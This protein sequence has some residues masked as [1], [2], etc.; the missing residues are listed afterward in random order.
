MSDT[1]ML[2]LLNGPEE[3]TAFKLGKRSLSI[4]RDKGNLIQLISNGVSRRHV[5]IRW[6]PG[7]YRLSDLNSTNGTVVN[8]KKVESVVLAINDLLQIGD[9]ELRVVP[10]RADVQDATFSR[11]KVVHGRQ[12]HPTE[13]LDLVT[14][15]LP[16]EEEEEEE[17]EAASSAPDY[18][19]VVNVERRRRR[20]TSDF[21]FSMVQVTMDDNYL[22]VA[23]EMISD[24][25]APD[26]IL[27][28]GAKTPRKL[29]VL[30]SHHRPS[31]RP[32]ERRVGPVKKVLDAAITDRRPVLDNYIPVPPRE[33]P[34]VGTAAAVC[35]ANGMGAIYVDS[36][37]HQKKFFL[38]SD[39][40]LLEQISEAVS[41]R[42]RG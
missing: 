18:R 34:S 25:I 8:R 20:D 12:R 6:T 28:L 15:D 38:G 23:M 3:G 40:K 27:I 7:G 35:L 37:N 36:Y 41:E 16:E 9:L 10:E 32:E 39:I 26:R 24:H 17:E 1:G 19:Q 29:K 13:T 30:A 31:L 5:M 2:V 22:G 14:D 33:G 21:E 11:P 4:G 42:M